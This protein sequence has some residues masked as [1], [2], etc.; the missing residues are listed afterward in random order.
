MFLLVGIVFAQPPLYHEFYGDVK[1]DNDDPIGDGTILLVKLDSSD[2][3]S[4]VVVS[5]GYHIIIQGDINSVGDEIGFYIGDELIGSSIFESFGLTN[6]DLISECVNAYCGDGEC[7]G[8]ETCSSCV[9]DC[10][11][12]LDPPNGGGTSYKECEDD[13]DNDNDG[14][15]DYPLDP[16]CLNANDNNETD[17]SNVLGGNCSND[18]AAGDFSCLTNISYREC[19]HYDNDNCLEWSSNINCEEGY[20]CSDEDAGCVIV[21]GDNGEPEFPFGK[22]FI[23]G[24]IPYA[25]GVGVLIVIAVSIWLIIRNRHNIPFNKMTFLKKDDDTRFYKLKKK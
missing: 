19:G 7:N 4:I 2:Y 12:C 16:G 10:G 3:S 23:E 15:I 8:G 9:A 11:A 5:G 17:V 22:L 20:I 25:V 13:L 14:L 6:L 1:C 21:D 18:C 24:I